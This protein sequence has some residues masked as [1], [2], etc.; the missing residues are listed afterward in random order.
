M[1]AYIVVD[2]TIRDTAAY[3][4]YKSLTPAS[5]AAYQGKFIIR[6]WPTEVLEGDWDPGRIVVLEFPDADLARQWWHSGEYE[7]AKKIRQGAS[8][9]NMLLITQPGPG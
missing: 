2:V 8:R 4:V 3:E 5:I 1:P 7:V 9:T 6:G